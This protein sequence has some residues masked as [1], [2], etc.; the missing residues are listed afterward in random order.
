M[1]WNLQF[2]KAIGGYRPVNISGGENA[3]IAYVKAIITADSVSRYDSGAFKRLEIPFTAITHDGFH[4]VEINEYTRVVRYSP[5][6]RGAKYIA[7]ELQKH[8][9]SVTG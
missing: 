4:A 2:S 3:I 9:N 1:P 5:E 7:Q 6:V 8:I